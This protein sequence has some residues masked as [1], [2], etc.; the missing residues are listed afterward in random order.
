M[1]I[2]YK[3]EKEFVYWKDIAVGDIFKWNDKYY[4]KLKE[5][6]ENGNC[7]ELKTCEITWFNENSCKFKDFEKVD[8]ELIIK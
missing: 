3:Q 4:L 2:T 1:K 8:A 7:F 6:R 5:P